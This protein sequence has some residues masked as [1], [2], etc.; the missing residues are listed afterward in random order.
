M[1]EELSGIEEQG[2][3]REHGVNLGTIVTV[4]L[5]ILSLTLFLSP[6]LSYIVVVLAA[7]AVMVKAPAGKT[8]KYVLLGM[9]SIAL[10]M[11]S[12]VLS[13]IAV[14]LSVKELLLMSLILGF[15][16]PMPLLL[17][18]FDILRIGREVRAAI[19]VA[20]LAAGVITLPL[21]GTVPLHLQDRSTTGSVSSVAE[22]VGFLGLYIAIGYAP[23]STAIIVGYLILIY[24]VMCGLRAYLQRMT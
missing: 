13:M 3:T 7:I 12:A 9:A 18:I 14:M 19:A 20:L 4:G 22:N 16:S 15:P 23:S 6:F 8:L 11:T 5:F 1:S 24:V 10:A 17:P 21:Y 2:V